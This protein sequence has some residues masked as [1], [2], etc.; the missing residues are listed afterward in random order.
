MSEETKKK[1]HPIVEDALEL[2]HEGVEPIAFAD[3]AIDELKQSLAEYFGKPELVAAVASLLELGVVLGEKGCPNAA[4]Q[5]I[6]VV[7][8]ATEALHDLAENK[9]SE[10]KLFF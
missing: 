6:E 1:L 5:I 10:R 8:H 3:W 7:T 4:I 9:K 2:A